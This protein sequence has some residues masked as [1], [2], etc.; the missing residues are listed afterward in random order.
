MPPSSPTEPVL[1]L[2]SM[3]FAR[4]EFHNIMLYQS[5]ETGEAEGGSDQESLS[6][7]RTDPG[8]WCMTWAG[9]PSARGHIHALSPSLAPRK[10]RNPVY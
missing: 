6:H 4:V 2:V 10:S 7:P 5:R 1:V 8:P 3:H 9:P